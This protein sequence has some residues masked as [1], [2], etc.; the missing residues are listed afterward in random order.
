MSYKEEFATVD[1]LKASRAETRGVDAFALS[2]IKAERQIRKLVTHLVFQFP[3][4]DTSDVSSLRKALADNRKV[5]FEGFINGFN[6]IY[7]KTIETMVGNKYQRLLG[8]IKKSIEH[9]NKIFHGQLTN[10]N[11]SRD[12]LLKYVDDISDWCRI[13]AN[14]ADDEFGYNGFDRNSF[15]KSSR[16][17]ISDTFLVTFHSVEDYEAFIRK[18]MQRR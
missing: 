12:D 9:R 13:L 15:Q 10:Q 3:C 8:R 18:N 14:A 6:S 4:F 1:F 2:L 5:Y 7:Q 11:L 17:N 16:K